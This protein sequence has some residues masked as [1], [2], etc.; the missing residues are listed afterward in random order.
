[1]VG[2]KISE[3]FYGRYVGEALSQWQKKNATGVYSR[4]C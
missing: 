1:M 3:N 2:K 4:S